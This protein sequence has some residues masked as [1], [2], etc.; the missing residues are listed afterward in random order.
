M[1]I[2]LEYRLFVLKKHT[3]RN[4]KAISTGRLIASELT[5]CFPSLLAREQTVR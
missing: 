1:R 2:F 5:A 3:L 4:D